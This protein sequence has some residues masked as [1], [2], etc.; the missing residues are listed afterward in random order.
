MEPAI[1]LEL[2]PKSVI[3]VF[4][5]VL[6]TDG[7]EASIA[8][9][10][11]A[12]GTALAHAGIELVG[13]VT[14]CAAALVAGEVWLDPTSTESD[15][16]DGVVMISGLPALGSMTNIWQTG[17]MSLEGMRKVSRYFRLFHR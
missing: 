4:V 15:S 17:R 8:A 10:V 11:T 5:T 16:A 12:A 7:L 13:I 6:E 14:A 2:F 3:E 9:A 1:R